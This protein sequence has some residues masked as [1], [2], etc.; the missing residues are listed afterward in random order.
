[1][2]PVSP[3]PPTRTFLMPAQKVP[4]YHFYPTLIMGAAA[5]PPPGFSPLCASERLRDD[6][7]VLRQ[8]TPIMDPQPR[9]VPQV[10]QAFRQGHLDLIALRSHEQDVRLY[11]ME[12][13]LGQVNF[14][15][16]ISIDIRCCSRLLRL[17]HQPV[18]RQRPERQDHRIVYR[19]LAVGV[20]Y[21]LQ[22][23]RLSACCKYYRIRV[24]MHDKRGIICRAWLR[25]EYPPGGSD[26]HV[27]LLQTLFRVES[28]ARRPVV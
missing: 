3:T 5:L 19:D 13:V 18:T 8:D 10:C 16:G 24:G 12:P 14:I 6:R 17:R 1:M 11:R 22:C 15:V 7:R 25:K 27:L 21:D 9:K 20:I 2:R 26:E 23:R 4:W 28:R